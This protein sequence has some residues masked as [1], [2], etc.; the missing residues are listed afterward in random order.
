LG[1]INNAICYETRPHLCFSLW[2]ENDKP[3]D[4]DIKNNTR[5]LDLTEP[6]IHIIN[7]ERRHDRKKKM[8]ERFG[9]NNITNYAFFKACDGATIIPTHALKKIFEGNDFNNNPGAIGC[10][11]SHL[12]LWK[13]LLQDVNNDFYL[14]L[15]DDIEFADD[16]SKKFTQI[17]EFEQKDIIFLGYSMM[18]AERNKIDISGSTIQLNKLNKTRYIGGFFSYL[19]NKKGAQKL[20]D[21]TDKNGIKHGIDY[22]IK[23][24]DGLDCYE[25]S[26][27]LTFTKWNEGNITIDTDIQGFYT[28][29][30]FPKNDFI[31]IQGLDHHGN[32]LYYRKASLPQYFQLADKDEKCVGF[33]T[34]GF[35][36][37]KIDKFEPSP[38]FGKQ[39]GLY[40]KKEY[41]EKYQ[42][43]QKRKSETH[44]IQKIYEKDSHILNDVFIETGSFEGDGIQAALDIGFKEIH[45]IEL[46]DKYYN[47][48]KERFKNFPQVHLHLGDS[49]TMLGHILS[50][51]NTGVTFWLDG[52]YSSTDT[53]CA[54]NYCS[55]VQQELQFI[56]QYNHPKHVILIDD[57]KDFTDK[58]IQW[59]LSTHKRCGYITKQDLEERLKEI[60]PNSKIYYFGP[61]CV[62][63]NKRNI[64][65]KMLCNWLSSAQLCK[66]WSN[67][68]E[69]G[70]RWK[71]IEITSEDDNIDYYVIINKPQKGAKFDPKKTIVFQMEPWVEDVGKNWGVKTWGE[72]ANPNPNDFL[73]IRGR[74]T[75]CYNN[76]FWQLELNYNELKSLTY[77]EKL[78]TVSSICSSKYY[79]VG[80]KHRI[81]FLKFLEK[82][83]DIEL[84]IYNKDN[85]HTFKNYKGPLHPYIDKSK[86]I[87]P[88]KYYF[89]VENNYERNFIT[90]KLWEPILCETLIFYYGCPNIKDYINEKA[91]VQLDM[92]DFEKS[93]EIIKKAIKED[94]WSQRIDIIRAE[95]KKLLNEMGFFP[96]I[97]KIINE[98]IGTKQHNY[99]FIHSCTLPNKGTYRLEYLIEKIKKSKAIN[100]FEK[101]FIN[102]IG[103]PID[104][105]YGN[106][107]EVSNSS[108]DPKLYEIPTLNKIK[109]FSEDHPSCNI[110]YL[111]NKGISYDD[112]NQ[113]V[114]DWIDYM[115]YFMVERHI[116]CIKLL[117]N[118][119]VIGCNYA[120]KPYKHF[121][122]NFWW[123]NSTH[124]K[125]CSIISEINVNKMQGESWLMENV[126]NMS[127]YSLHQSNINHYHQRYPEKI[128]KHF[129]C[130]KELPKNNRK[131]KDNYKR[132]KM[133][134]NWSSSEELCKKWSTMCDED[135]H[136]KDIEIT[137]EDENID[138]YVI[139]NKPQKGAK[140]DPKKTLIFQ[141]E[142]WIYNATKDWGV[143]TWAE[144]SIPDEK[145]FLY[146]GRHKNHLNAVQWEIRTPDIIPEER[147]NKALIFLSEKDFDW[148]HKKRI[149]FLK[150]LEDWQKGEEGRPSLI[151][152]YG[153]ENYH[154]LTQYKGPL[155]DDKKENHYI[156]YKYCFAVENNSERN[157]A[158]EKIWE[159]ILCE[160]L[161]FY[162]GCPGLE[163]HIN[164][165]AFVRL[166]ITDFEG[167]LAIIQQ[168]IK[169]DWWSQRIDII[170]QEKQRII[171][172]LGF[173]PRLREI[174]K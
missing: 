150:K 21:Y 57:M 115:L 151:D 77:N 92:N 51:I 128:Y 60:H 162:W 16:Y 41:Y 99:C 122:G 143:H 48:C 75:D 24:I 103:L 134:C 97:E 119:N 61:A 153:R 28:P 84:D 46:S 59:N 14:I 43:K 167:S 11:M 132:I 147:E 88:Y 71:N 173:F 169:E 126:N 52:H 40:I 67:M 95:K 5:A 50:K 34:L 149:E 68:C 83:G 17:C 172:E 163:K 29:I 130:K 31:F 148:G 157:Y 62:A 58:S 4:S 154:S 42:A 13:Q 25:V 145:K 136:W 81:G 89:M 79:D 107:F 26:P 47:I 120:D 76:V 1:K 23:I 113:Y 8:I 125:K 10:A 3:V 33:N 142:P 123:A 165:K 9:E 118:Y 144:W 166:N 152:V 90:E 63:Y 106:K 22:L 131:S 104:N 108:N 85:K 110:L 137:S 102:N 161:T 12:T 101:V 6:H 45:S 39:D 114:N 170:R 30:K 139:I 111:H 140:F 171:N 117:N 91:F 155:Q 87:V 37:D 160:C 38:Y 135:L 116:K 7:L 32:D 35:F 109:R 56:K 174:I 18:E 53:A 98:D 138:Y 158:T 66:K 54:E 80:H 86:G 44:T 82:K 159:P 36:K 96:V 164:E 94:W 15:E 74:K 72:W 49:G 73:A 20:V 19:I 78:N 100:I 55:P 27:Q 69:D 168:A 129:V 105:N 156:N 93:Y 124:L 2:D 112:K 64:K 141:M 133:L 65:I 70:F 127:H 121:S 146:V